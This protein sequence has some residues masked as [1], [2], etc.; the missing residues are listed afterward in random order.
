MNETRK[1]LESIGLPSA[2]GYDLPTSSKRFPDGA[3]YRF[4]IPSVE[5]PRCLQTVIDEAKK[6]RLTIH[7]ISQGSG[8]ML[9]TDDEI[10]EMAGMGRRHAIEVNLFVGPRSTFD[11]GAQVYSQAGKMLGLGPRGWRLASVPLGPGVGPRSAGLPQAAGGGTASAVGG[12]ASWSDGCAVGC[13]AA[14]RVASSAA[15][16]ARY[17]SPAAW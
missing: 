8:I 9:L 14:S 10:L 2:D 13:G 6:H 17:S 11:I 16:A 3:Q 4:E 12:T 15:D 7:R 1:F 5:G